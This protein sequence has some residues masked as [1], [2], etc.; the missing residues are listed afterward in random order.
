MPFLL[1]AGMGLSAFMAGVGALAYLGM[2]IVIP[3]SNSFT[4]NDVPVT[5]SAFLEEMWPFFLAYPLLL[6]AFGLVAYGLWR[7]KTWSREVMMAFWLLGAA[8]SVIVQ[9]V[10]PAASGDFLAG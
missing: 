9:F 3:F 6:A 1:L 7:E 2:V 8:A 10:S 5:R 4:M